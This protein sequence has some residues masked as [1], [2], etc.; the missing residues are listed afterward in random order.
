MEIRKVI[1]EDPK[2]TQW[3]LLSQFVYPPNIERYQNGLGL[4]R[5]NAELV[6]YISGCISQA[7]AY[8]VS[9]AQAALDISPLL[10]YYGTTNLLAGV[11]ALIKGIIPPIKD[12]GMKLIGIEGLQEELRV[13]SVRPRK[14]IDGALS[15]FCSV[16]S[17]DCNIVNGGEWTLL[18]ILASVPDIRSDFILCYDKEKLFTLP[19]EIV[20][21]LDFV[22]DRASLRDVAKI[23]NFDEALRRTRGFSESYIQ[24]QPTK[25]HL[26]LHRKLNGNEIGSLSIS[27]QKYLIIPHRKNNQ[28]IEPSQ[29]MLFL[30]GIYVLGNL[31][32]YNPEFWHPFVKKFQTG[33]KLLVERFLAVAERYIPNLVLDSIHNLHFQFLFNESSM[34][35]GGSLLTKEDVIDIVS[36]MRQ[37]GKL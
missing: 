24:P 10:L 28:W 17:P 6:N 32:R 37:R 26:I 12:H 15:I 25:N 31:S 1:T 30:M 2:R 18:E 21:K 23:G 9:A 36:N 11:W 8:Y 29:L 4:T 22:N 13:L 35:D 27:G 20:R 34:A 7:N 14:P 5:P 16:F 3:A 19:V 33:E